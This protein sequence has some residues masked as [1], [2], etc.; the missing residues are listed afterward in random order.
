MRPVSGFFNKL[1]D[2][3]GSLLELSFREKESSFTLSDRAEQQCAQDRSG[4]HA[5]GCQG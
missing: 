1:M 3:I 4:R 2:N 5:I